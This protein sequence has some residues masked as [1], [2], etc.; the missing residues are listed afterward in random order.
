MTGVQTCALPIYAILKLVGERDFGDGCFDQNLHGQD[1]EFADRRF[2]GLIFAVGR[3]NDQC[4]IDRV[5]DD[6]RAALLP[7]RARGERDQHRPADRIAPCLDCLQSALVE[8][9]P[10]G[11]DDQPRRPGASVATEIFRE[12]ALQAA[13]VVFE[14]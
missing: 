9:F 8:P 14:R 11:D 10:F 6:P 13:G 5:R 12:A 3:D 7:E 1:V 2:D 4:A